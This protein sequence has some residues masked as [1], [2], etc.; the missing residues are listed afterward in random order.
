MAKTKNESTANAEAYEDVKKRKKLA[1]KEAKLMLQIDIVRKDVVKARKKI[2]QNENALTASNSQLQALEDQLAK[3]REATPDRKTKENEN[4]IKD[5]VIEVS[6]NLVRQ[7]EPAE[8]REDSS[9]TPTQPETTETTK[10]KNKN[11]KIGKADKRKKADKAGNT[12]KVN[13]TEENDTAAEI[14]LH[15]PEGTETTEAADLAA[16][17]PQENLTIASGEGSIDILNADEHG[18]NSQRS[19]TDNQENGTRARPTRRT[20]RRRR[21]TTNAEPDNN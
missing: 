8:G 7:Q 10:T 21:T 14:A 16:K 12:N 1:K 18:Q 6:E 17:L 20:A 9:E 2:A 3:L 4:V 5:G 13:K 15:T 11:N 19:E